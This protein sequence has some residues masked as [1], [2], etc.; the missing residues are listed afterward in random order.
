MF[1]SI[2]NCATKTSFSLP[3]HVFRYEACPAAGG[4]G[5]EVRQLPDQAPE[6]LHR[7]RG[8]GEQAGLRIRQVGHSQPLSPTDS[9]IGAK[10]I[11]L[12]RESSRLHSL[13]VQSRRLTHTP[14]GHDTGE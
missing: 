3:A 2:H 6:Y 12:F 7:E 11:K 10:L 1:S 14:R 5:G 9:H 13:G 4:G 8:R